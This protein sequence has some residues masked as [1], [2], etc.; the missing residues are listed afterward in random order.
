MLEDDPPEHNPV[1]LAYKMNGQWLS[2]MR[3]GPVRMIVPE[4][5]GFK[6]VKWIKTVVLSNQYGATLRRYLR[7]LENNDIDSW[8]KTCAR[9]FVVS[10]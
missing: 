7:P 1:I 2:G 6:S 3:G 8:M 4:A 5:Y 10:E 9:A